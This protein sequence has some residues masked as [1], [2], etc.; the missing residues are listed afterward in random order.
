MIKRPQENRIFYNPTLKKTSLAKLEWFNEVSKQFQVEFSVSGLLFYTKFNEPS[1]Y[2]C[3][4]LY[5]YDHEERG[6]ERGRRQT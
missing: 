1:I 3:L 2:F 6:K 4:I 5:I